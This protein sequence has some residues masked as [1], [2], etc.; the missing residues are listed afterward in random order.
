MPSSAPAGAS[1]EEEDAVV[2]AG[3][4]ATSSAAPDA[5]DPEPQRNK[6]RRRRKKKRRP[7]SPT[8]EEVAARR[9]VLRWACPG[10]EVVAADDGQAAGAGRARVRRP[11]VA[12]ELHA[13]SARSDGTLSPA[14]LVERAHRNGVSQSFRK[15]FAAALLGDKHCSSAEC[16]LALCT[17][18]AFSS[19][20][21]SGWAKN[22]G[23]TFS[24]N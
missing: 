19:R 20:T 6:S 9:F 17:V 23:L 21:N 24:A 13:H 10:R 16:V 15:L 4:I 18:A 1:T 22:F 2:A 3:A 11:R 8:E 14:E 5:G 12:V 7:R